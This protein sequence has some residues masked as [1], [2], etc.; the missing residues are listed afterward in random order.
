MPMATA[1]DRD[2]AQQELRSLNQKQIAPM[3]RYIQEEAAKNPIY[4]YNVAPKGIADQIISLGSMGHYTIFPCEPG[5]PYSRPT[6]IARIIPE[7]IPVDM[8]KIELR[9][10]DGMDVAR[11]II[12]AGPF[13][14]KSQDLTRMGVFISAGEKPTEQEL[15]EARK[16]LSE[17][18]LF[19]VQEADAYWM[20]GPQQ[21]INIS[22]QHRMACNELNLE[23]EWNKT[24]KPMAVCP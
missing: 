9:Y 4:I 18:Y 7:G 19:L 16:R 21:V 13:K 22:A 5:Q 2:R 3:P 14:S 1:Q 10:W 6:V 8:R 17:Y 24:P 15:A 20:Q 23:R 11:D 12:G